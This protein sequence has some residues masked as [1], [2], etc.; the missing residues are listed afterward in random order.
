M[1]MVAFHISPVHAKLLEE[2]ILEI[3]ANVGL[4]MLNN[5]APHVQ[6]VQEMNACSTAEDY[7][8]NLVRSA[9]H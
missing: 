1:G 8:Q 2:G 6:P 3:V 4:D 5:A 9:R 7:I